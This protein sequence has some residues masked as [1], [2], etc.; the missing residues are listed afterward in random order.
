M[1]RL[2]SAPQPARRRPN[3]FKRRRQLLCRDAL[4]AARCYYEVEV[5][6]NRVEIALAYRRIDRKSL[7]KL[8]AF[9]ENDMSW[10]LSRSNVYSFSHNSNSMTL[11]AEP[12]HRKVGVYLQHRE[13]LLSFYEVADRMKL[14]HR[15]RASFTEPLYPG[16]WLGENCRIKICDF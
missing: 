16:F 9:G 14:L 10:C 13:G 5:E 3:R 2:N 1:V 15:V 8:S 11:Q 12:V 7:S 6:G 4:C